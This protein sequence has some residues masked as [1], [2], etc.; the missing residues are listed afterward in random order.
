MDLG[1]LAHSPHHA[2]DLARL[3]EIG[4]VLNSSVE[5]DEILDMILIGVTAGQGLAFNRAFLLLIDEHESILHCSHAIGPENPEE[6]QHDW[7][8]LENKRLTLREMMMNSRDAQR[9]VGRRGAK[10][11]DLLRVPLSDTNHVLVRAL[12][13]DGGS[14]V[15]R[16]AECDSASCEMISASLGVDQFALVPIHSRGGAVGVLVADNAI[17][18]RPIDDGDLELLR[19]FAGHAGTAIEKA[20]LYM[21]IV[22]EK[23]ELEKVHK[24]LRDNQQTIITLQRLSDLGE[25]TARMAHEIRNPLVSIGGFSRRLLSETA[26]GDPRRRQL[27]IIVNEVVR[28]E[29]ILAEILDFARPLTPRLERTDL[30]DLIRETLESLSPE[31]EGLGIELALELDSTIHEVPIDSSLFRIALINV[32]RNA[33]QAIPR[34]VSRVGRITVRTQLKGAVVEVAV[35][36]NGTGI[37]REAAER[38][39]DPFFTTKPSGSGLGLAIVSQILKEHGG[40]VRFESRAGEGAAFF[41]D[42][43]LEKGSTK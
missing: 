4:E 27:Q 17:T 43:P 29:T 30:N 19:L 5:L 24:E 36:D 34:R 25:M 14:S 32:I 37:A 13:P 26:V 31:R 35:I 41:M 3:V 42:L 38:L 15:V 23:N 9:G 21:K 28:L 12:Q 33:L 20:R 7:T 22:E 39:F 40:Q 8:E 6:A 11:L 18:K 2:A 10:I 16:R 1:T